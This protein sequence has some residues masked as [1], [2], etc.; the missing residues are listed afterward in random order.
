MQYHRVIVTD[1]GPPAVLNVMVEPELPEPAAGQVRVRV[2]ASSATFTDTLIRKG[3]YP[4]LDEAPPFTPGYDFVGRVDK[5]GAG[6]SGLTVGQRVADLTQ[7]GS[8][9]AYLCHPAERLVPVPET[10]DAAAAETLVLSFLTAYQCLHRIARVQPGQRILVHGGSGAVGLAFLQLGR[11]YGVEIVSTASSANLPLLEEHGAVA[12]DYRAPDYDERLRAAA[13]AGFAAAFDGIGGDS[14]RRSFRLLHSGGVLVPFGFLQMGRQVVRKTLL[15]SVQNTLSLG[16]GI[17]QLALWNAL[18][19]Q[20]AVKFYS[21]SS[22]REKSPDAFRDD[23]QRLM[24]MLAAGELQPHIA[25]RFP[26]EQIV[27]AHEALD[28]GVRGRLVIVHNS[29]PSARRQ[30]EHD[31]AVT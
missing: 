25:A 4:G 6:V 16:M 3:M 10:V 23:L 26:L 22:M 15:V 7:A 29:D 20:R 11:L 27:Q 2:E 9:T 17:A 1:Y 18:P 5:L 8:N 21:I 30:G 19:N 31:S 14:F 28:A 13:G 12:V 24:Q